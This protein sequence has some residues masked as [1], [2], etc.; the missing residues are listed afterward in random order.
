MQ[1][2]LNQTGV[3][4]TMAVYL[5]TDHYD[6]NPNVISATGIMK[7]L[8]QTILIPRVPQTMRQRDVTA[9]VK[10]RMGTS[11]HDGVEKAW[12]D[13][14]TRNI[15]L[16]ALGHSE[17]VRE[18]IV[19][20]S[21]ALLRNHGYT[22]KNFL[23]VTLDKNPVPDNPIPVYTEIRQFKTVLGRTVSGK[24]D[25]VAEGKIRDIK[26]TSTY[27]WSHGLKKEDYQLQLSIYRWLN[28]SIVTQ[29]TGAIEFM[30]TDWKAGARH[31]EGYPPAAIMSLDI[32]LLSL[33]ET[34]VYIETKLRLHDQYHGAHEQEI[35]DCT[36][37]ELWR[38]P[39]TF[40]Y[41]KDPAAH[42]QGKRSTKNFDNSFDAHNLLQKQN[43]GGIV[44]EKTGEVV[45]CKY[46][47]AFSICTQKDRYIADGTLN[48]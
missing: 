40:K 4:L 10:S 42:A 29:D 32:P 6:H 13:P 25:F 2:Y 36:D 3:S 43:S 46:C 44:V 15:A 30:F 22:D 47:D 5:A 28:P 33:E 14:E 37:K 20:N 48:F 35:P 45:A 41:Y 18:R 31:Q 17:A 39:T 8:R 16:K 7:P 12:V 24:F 1:T 11:L 26:S 23:G 38:K 21:E 34:Q 27:T 9:V 19:V